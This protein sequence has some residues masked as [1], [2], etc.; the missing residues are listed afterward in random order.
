MEPITEFVCTNIQGEKMMN[1][2]SY[3]LN[4]HHDVYVNPSD[5]VVLTRQQ[6]QDLQDENNQCLLEIERLQR[7]VLKL[8]NLNNTQATMLSKD[9]LTYKMK[10]DGYMKKIQWKNSKYKI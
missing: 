7:E 8:N 6:L 5:I 10:N 1:D 4:F 3:S 2:W 9:S